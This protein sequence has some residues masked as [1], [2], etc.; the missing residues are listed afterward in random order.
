MC[1]PRLLLCCCAGDFDAAATPPP[2]D[3][4][5]PGRP[6]LDGAAL[7]AFGGP[8]EAVRQYRAA[9]SGE[10]RANLFCVLFDHA[11][12]QLQQVQC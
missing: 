11:V 3:P 4:N 1:S 10:A 6:P 5:L 12:A 7:A 8:G 9:P 2:S